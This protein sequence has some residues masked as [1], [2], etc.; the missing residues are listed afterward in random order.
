MA[1]YSVEPTNIELEAVLTTLKN[2]NDTVS[3]R[4]VA[5]LAGLKES[6]TRNAILDLEEAGKIRRVPTKQFS[7][8]FVR[9]RYEVVE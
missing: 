9:Y 8:H 7:K 4:Q 6:R 3:I 2:I 5:E 1:T